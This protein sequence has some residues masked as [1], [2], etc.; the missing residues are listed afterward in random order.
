MSES[1]VKSQ[2]MKRRAFMKQQ[3]SIKK[4]LMGVLSIVLVVSFSSCSGGRAVKSDETAG[5]GQQAAKPTPLQKRYTKIVFQKLDADPKIEAD[6]PEVVADCEKAAIAA[7]RSKNLFQ[8]V[9]KEGAG[10]RYD[11][12]T[13]LVKPRLVSM[14]IVSGAARMWGGAFAG[15]SDMVVEL[16]MTDAVSRMIVHEKVLS[17]ANNPFAAAWVGGSSDRSL[18]TDMGKM[19]SDYIES[20]MPAR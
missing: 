1:R 4:M 6:Y 13:L 20:I 3:D 10:G 11:A 14:R 2:N 12:Q 9:E 19:I 18:S 5:P 15:A 8:K 7:L 17:T 16:K